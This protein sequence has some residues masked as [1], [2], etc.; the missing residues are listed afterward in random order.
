[1][2]EGVDKILGEK[3]ATFYVD[4]SITTLSITKGRHVLGRVSSIHDIHPLEFERWFV[5][6]LIRAW[7]TSIQHTPIGEITSKGY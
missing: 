5:L 4:M 3:V 2:A 1:M 6:Q 7:G